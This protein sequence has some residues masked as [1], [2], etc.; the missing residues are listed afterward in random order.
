MDADMSDTASR[1][2]GEWTI[3]MAATLREDLLK[4]VAEGVHVFDLSGV[5]E[6]DS[7]G[8]QLLLAAQR[9]LARQ[10]H[11]LVLSACSPSVSQVL[12]SYGLDADL[13]GA[14]TLTDL[15]QEHA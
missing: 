15:Q 2:D 9:S 4:R 14:D 5:T 1:L 11:E 12:K 6:M 7:A 13:R 3:P 8:L 10:G